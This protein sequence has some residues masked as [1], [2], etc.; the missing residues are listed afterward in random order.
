[1]DRPLLSRQTAAFQSPA[2]RQISQRVQKVGGINLG[3]GV[4]N[5]PAPPEVLEAAQREIA[6]GNNQYTHS[7]G[8]AKLRHALSDKLRSWNRM[9][10][11]P[12]EN[13][14]VTAGATGAFEA[15]CGVFLSPGDEAVIFEPSYPYHLQALRRYE[16]T[17]RYARLQRP[18]WSIDWEEL[19]SLINPRTKLVV[20]NTPGNPHGR[21]WTPDE[22]RQLAELLA[23]TSAWLVTDEIYEYM[24]F[25]GRAHVSP[26]SLPELADRTL[27]MGGYSKT[28]SVT[29]WRIGYMVVPDGLGEP[30]SQF[31]DAV[32]ACSPTPLQ[33]AVAEGVL[34]LS[35]EFY[36]QMQAKYQAKRDLFVAGLRELG[37]QPWV[38]QGSYYLLCDMA[39]LF[40]GK[41]S[42]EISLEMIDRTGVGAVPSS[43]FLR[44]AEGQTWVRF[45]LA[46][47]DAVL[48]DALGRL[49]RLLDS[50]S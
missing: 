22:Y 48:V 3:Q 34:S 16:A 15:V 7:R 12:D 32:Y 1:M 31:L 30:V 2:L 25:D 33:A 21:V 26:G 29:G 13:V 6:R 38:P 11:N 17:I 4:C 43:D 47:E 36:S 5:L 44:S 27:T 42:Q 28:F 50:S 19:R 18:D 35:P 10:T 49:R 14:L 46:Q 8:Y 37:L 9:E 23:G 40:P 24:T 39:P 45:C 20:V 41:T